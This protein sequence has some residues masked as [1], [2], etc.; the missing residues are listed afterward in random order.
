VTGTGDF[1]NKIIDLIRSC[2]F[3]VAIFSDKPPA[4]TL[5]NIFFEV[6]IAAVLGKPIQLVLTGKN[7]AS[8]DFVRS[9]WIAYIPRKE[10]DLRTTLA[11]G[12]G[13][14]ADYYDTL[15]QV[16]LKARNADLELAFERFKQAI[17][18][19]DPAG[20]REGMKG[21]VN[22]LEEQSESETDDMA[23]HRDRLHRSATQFL[24]LLP[25]PKRAI[26]TQSGAKAAAKPRRQ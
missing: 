18:I 2:G 26:L 11:K 5:A 10:A 19:G 8:S 1:L 4:K 23:S 24:K 20:A 21:V 12:I 3:A 9:E 7:P 22:R 25:R 14:M 15:G 6:G 16:A 13:E 17:L